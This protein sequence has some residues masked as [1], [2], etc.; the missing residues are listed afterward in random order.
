MEG[1][2]GEGVHFIQFLLRILIGNFLYDKESHN[3]D[4]QQLFFYL[5][6]YLDSLVPV[7]VIKLGEVK[8]SLMQYLF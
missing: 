7:F 4:D 8:L 5:F 3:N 1:G 6:F 2:G